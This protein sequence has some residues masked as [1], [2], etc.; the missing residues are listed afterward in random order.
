MGRAAAS[1]GGGPGAFH[2]RARCW[3][4]ASPA[5]FIEWFSCRCK[6]GL[7]RSTAWAVGWLGRRWAYAD[8]CGFMRQCYAL[9]TRAVPGLAFGFPGVAH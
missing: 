1:R 2:P 9:H 5:R 3:D 4:P 7:N 8:L 6:S